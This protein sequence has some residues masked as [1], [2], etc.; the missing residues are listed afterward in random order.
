[1]RREFPNIIKAKIIQRAMNSR[2]QVVCE[3]CGLV[4]AGKRFEIDHTIAEALVV[5]KSRPLTPDDGK[6]LGLACCHAPKTVDD[7]GNIARAK[8]RELKFHGAARRSSNP[9]PG[10]KASRFKKR[11][12]GTVVLRGLRELV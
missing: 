3:G 7:V 5:D 1:M 4:L 9:I 6:L 11:I 8:R 10:S 2:G 12:D